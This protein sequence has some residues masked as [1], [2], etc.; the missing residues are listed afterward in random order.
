MQASSSLPTVRAGVGRKCGMINL[1]GE[2]GRIYPDTFLPILL[3]FLLPP[4]PRLRPGG[5]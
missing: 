3:T 5:T 2:Y 4:A 1:R